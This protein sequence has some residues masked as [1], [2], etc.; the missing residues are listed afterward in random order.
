[1]HKKQL[2][3]KEE[4]ERRNRKNKQKNPGFQ[5]ISTSPRYAIRKQTS[6]VYYLVLCPRL[7]G[8]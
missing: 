1:M 6:T 8:C 7:S 5:I 4:K 2:L 3:L